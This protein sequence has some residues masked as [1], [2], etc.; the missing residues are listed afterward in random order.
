MFDLLNLN[1]ETFGLDISDLSLKLAKVK[2][3][4]GKLSLVVLGQESLSPGIIKRGE[5]QNVD[6]L[7]K[8][9]KKLIA[10][11]P[12]INTRHVVVSLPEEKSFVRVMQM[13]K[14]TIKEIKSAIHFEAENYI[15]FSVDKVYLDS[16]I[17]PPL[18]V[19]KEQIEV[20]LVALPKKTA[21]S[22]IDALYKAGL[23][24]VAMEI[25]SQA[26]ARALIF[27]QKTKEPV[28]L[29]DL[30]T[31]G[32]SL[33]VYFGNSLRFSSFVPVSSNKFTKAIA[34][35]LGIELSEAEKLKKIHGFQ[36]IGNVGN[37]VFKALLPSLNELVEQIK[38]HIDYY[39]TRPTDEEIISNGKIIKKIFLCG[40]GVN[41]KGLIKFLSEET[42]LIVEKGDA[43]VN[44][45]EDIKS[46]KKLSKQNLLAYTTAIGLALR[47]IKL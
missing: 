36:K 12:E 16:Q 27:K 6:K 37:K 47:N 24:P 41:L 15:P 30:G 8:A 9:I 1:P 33:S 38:K 35:S 10:K 45:P 39:E 2:K 29:I 25:E 26:T 46:K 22:Y 40:G 19:S 5:I 32:T 14:M 21:D 3:Q 43:L 11:T 18:G 17:I 44:L 28:L 13:P 34:D 4:N 42:G 31:S 23:I 20:L 7:S